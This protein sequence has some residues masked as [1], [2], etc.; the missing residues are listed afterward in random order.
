MIALISE[1]L[2]NFSKLWIFLGAAAYVFAAPSSE[3]INAWKQ[4]VLTTLPKINNGW[5]SREKAERL[6]DLVLK[7][8]PKVCVEIGVFEG[9]SVFPIATTLQFL[10]GGVIYCI[11]PWDRM[12]AIRYFNPTEDKESI[13]WWEKVNFERIYKNFQ[14]FIN[15]RKLNEYCV[16]LRKSSSDAAEDIKEPIDFLHI[17]GNHSEI[18]SLLDVRTYLPKVRSGGYICYNDCFWPERIAAM[19][20]LSES[21]EFVR[22]INK[23][24]CILLRKL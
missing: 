22:F 18:I 7:E 12:E 20:L 17:D 9:A 4:R 11:D 16:I 19:D 13:E 15:I 5:C 2:L 3:E 24:N 1:V 14:R 10:G 21:C 6:M 8:K 23:D